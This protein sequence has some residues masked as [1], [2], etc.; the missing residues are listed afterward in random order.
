VVPE[1][2]YLGNETAIDRVELIGITGEGPS[3]LY[4]GSLGPTDAFNVSVTVPPNG[5]VLRARGSRATSDGNLFFYTNPIR[6]V[7]AKP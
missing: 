5:I 7:T 6:I 4:A 1:R 3:V 2:D